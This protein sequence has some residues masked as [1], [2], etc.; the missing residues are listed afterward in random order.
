MRGPR[1]PDR[2]GRRRCHTTSAFDVAGQQAPVEQ[3]GFGTITVAWTEVVESTRQAAKTVIERDGRITTTGDTG[4][5]L[6][7]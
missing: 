5:F 6:C 2:R 1:P 3:A 7:R 4:A